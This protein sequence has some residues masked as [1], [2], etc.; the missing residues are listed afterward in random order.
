[1]HT[2]TYL[3]HRAA[4]EAAPVREV[5]ITRFSIF[6]IGIFY[7]YCVLH[8]LSV[9]QTLKKVPISVIPLLLPAKKNLSARKYQ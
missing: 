7:Q 6:G 2:G 9:H 3:F 5:R 1:M 8:V 4:V